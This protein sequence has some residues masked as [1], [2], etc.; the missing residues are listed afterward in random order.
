M[1][2]NKSHASSLLM[3]ISFILFS[4]PPTEQGWCFSNDTIF[5]DDSMHPINASSVQNGDFIQ[6]LSLDNGKWIM[7][8]TEVGNF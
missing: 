8:T 5:L 4:P 6:T 2:I 3:L 7:T 1:G